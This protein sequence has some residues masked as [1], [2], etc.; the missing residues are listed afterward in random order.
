MRH[1]SIERV[2]GR[3]V[4][5]APVRVLPYGER[6][7]LL[8]VTSTPEAMALYAAVDRARS[9]P[10]TPLAETQLVL[11]DVVEVVPAA[12][13]VLVT[14]TNAEAVARAA[15]VLAALPVVAAADD[16][17]GEVV[18]CV[19]YDG[20][21]L[22]DVA[23]LTGLST[24]ELVARHTGSSWRVA[25][26]GFAPGFAYLTGG[27][28]ALAVPR[29]ASPRPRVP[30]GSVALAG[31]YSAVYPSASPGGWRLIGTTSA[32]VFDVQ[33]NPPALLRPGTTVR[34]EPC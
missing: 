17:A 20:P 31:E 10:G 32:A 9:R 24:D 18:I 8:E 28:P 11:A 13:T 2:D 1:G 14:F 4:N 27:D 26:I 30:A 15:P 16:D 25:F 23:A 7:L 33:R 6:A 34:F 3:P 5:A 21:D 19:H 12:R 29:L 22:A